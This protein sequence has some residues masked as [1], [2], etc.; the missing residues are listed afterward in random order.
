[1]P[2]NGPL[3]EFAAIKQTAHD[4][5]YRWQVLLGVCVVVL[6]ASVLG[7]VALGAVLS[8][9]MAMRRER[10]VAVQVAEEAKAKHSDISQGETQLRDQLIAAEAESLR[11]KGELDVAAKEQNRLRAAESRAIQRAEEFQRPAAELPA[12]NRSAIL[13]AA[14]SVRLVCSIDEEAQQEGLRQGMVIEEMRSALRGIGT[15]VADESGSSTVV[16]SIDRVWQSGN[17]SVWLVR[18]YLVGRWRLPGASTSW[19]VILLE[20]TEICVSGPA[21]EATSQI[22]KAVSD[23]TKRVARE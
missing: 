14:K 4:P 3:N 15:L 6:V 21:R 7:N 1:V 16:A 2:K 18:A 9:Y 10:D 19:S 20:E 23:A 17:D 11:L 12:A 22:L 5:S 8:K 13:A